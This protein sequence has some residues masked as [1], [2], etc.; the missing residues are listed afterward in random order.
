M[1]LLRE[2][3]LPFCVSLVEQRKLVIQKDS[4]TPLRV[5]LLDGRLAFEN[6]SF[7]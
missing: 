4:L 2:P 1:L 3:G 7:R 5:W 6:G